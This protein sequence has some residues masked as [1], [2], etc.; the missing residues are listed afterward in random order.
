MVKGSVADNISEMVNKT[1][2]NPMQVGVEMTT[3]H[4][5][6]VN[7]FFKA[8]LHFVGQLKRDYEKGKFDGRNEFA[9]KCAKVMIDALSAE[10]L[11]V[12]EYWANEYDDILK[13]CWE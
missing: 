6:L 10:G 9:C 5:Y 13:K 4:R 1:S 12:P 8:T 11:Y 2:F 7:E 3:D